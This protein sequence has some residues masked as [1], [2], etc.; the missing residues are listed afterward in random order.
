MLKLK[1]LLFCIFIWLVLSWGTKVENFVAGRDTFNFTINLLSKNYGANQFDS[2]KSTNNYNKREM[3]AR[4]KFKIQSHIPLNSK[5]KEMLEIYKENV[6]EFTEEEKQLVTNAV[7]YLFTKFRG[8]VPLIRAW[9]I[10]KLNDDIDWGYPHTLGNNIVLSK[11]VISENVK[12]LAKTLFHEQLHII[13][14]NEPIIFREFY[15]KQWKFQ[16][17]DLPDDEWINTYLVHN[18]DSEDFYL[19]KLSE[20]LFALPLPTTFNHHHK[21]DQHALFLTSNLKILAKDDQP[22]VEPLKNL[23]QYNQRFYNSQSLYHP[24]EIFA[25]MLSEMVFNELSV[26]DIDQTAFDAI[27]KQLK[28]YF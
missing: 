3:S 18:P 9:N 21:F 7:T 17:F 16:K 10:I 4:S 11:H 6:M 1:L 20:E 19:Y 14:R 26:S 24:N 12:E 13:Q 23:V 28:Y 22:H 8:K 5:R 25:T 27:F 2:N 15:E